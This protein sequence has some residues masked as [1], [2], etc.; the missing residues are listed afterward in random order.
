MDKYCIMKDQ[1]A[2]KLT[3]QL[4]A[5]SI[6]WSINSSI[7]LECIILQFIAGITSLRHNKVQFS[8]KYHRAEAKTVNQ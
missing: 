8:E 7:A 3:D 2:P 5:Q 1:V 4:I 6:H